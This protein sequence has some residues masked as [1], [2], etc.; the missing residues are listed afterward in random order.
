ME[1]TQIVENARRV[2]ERCKAATR[3]SGRD[4]DAVRVVAVAKTQPRSQAIAV[5]EAGIG[6]IGEN[7]VQEA[8]EKWSGHVGRDFTLHMIG[9]LQ[10]NKARRAA[11]LFD[12]IQSCDSLQLARRLSALQQDPPVRV[13]LEV[14]MSGE[15]SKAG[16]APFGL[17]S[18]LS[19]ILSL[20]N[21]R[22]E[23]L[24]TIAP[25]TRTPEDARPHFR[26][27]RQLSEDLRAKYDSLGADLSMGM[28]GDFEIAIEE[29]ATIV[30]VGRAIYGERPLLG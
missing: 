24:M 23:G 7:R 15:E 2:L 18:A 5:L 10:R 25:A 6:H 29:G 14:N 9:R 12:V 27:L 1:Q 30:R 20:S 28:T 13:L 3:R 21:L 26:G 16:F 8:E 11:S 19:E 22:L 17:R 4:P